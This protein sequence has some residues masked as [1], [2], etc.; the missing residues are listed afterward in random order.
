MQRV[1]VTPQNLNDITEMLQSLIDGTG[2]VLIDCNQGGIVQ[3]RRQDALKPKRQAVPPP[4]PPPNPVSLY[5]DERGIPR[6]KK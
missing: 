6:T 1:T 2:T 3:I 5:E 4:P